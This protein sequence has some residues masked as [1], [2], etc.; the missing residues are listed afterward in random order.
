MPPGNTL[1]GRMALMPPS[2]FDRLAQLLN[3]ITP[4]CA[5]NGAPVPLTIGEPQDAP[6][7]FVTDILNEQARAYGRYPPI[8]GTPT[9][10]AACARWLMRRFAVPPGALDADTQI[11]PLAG[12]REGLFYTLYALVPDE[13]AGGRPVVLVPNPFYGVYPA[14]VL[15]A[16]AEPY[17]VPSRRETGF[18][19]DFA[20][21][22]EDVLRRTVAAFYCSPSNP[23]S[24]CASEADWRRVFATADTYEFTVLA[25]ECYAEIYDRDAPV[26]ALSV[27]YAQSG[28]CEKLISFHSLSKRSNLPGLRSGFMV[29]PAPVMAALRG[30]RNLAAPQIPIPAMAASAAAWDDDAHVEES[31]ALYRRRFDVAERLL[32]NLGGFRRPPGG[33]YLW[34]DV[35][36]GAG[37][38]A[39]LWRRSGVRVMPGAF[40]GREEIPG[41][42]ASNPGFSYVRIALVHDLVTITAALERVAETLD[43][44]DH[45]A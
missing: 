29:G 35:G 6:P 33:F 30:F 32:G 14:A 13:K 22:P 18:L 34:L 10:R 12:S 11:L 41:N 38:A 27:R 2:S 44:W 40:M 39:E 37:F 43:R 42:P 1:P 28:G 3:P 16:G 20:C 19:P 8:A 7:R 23:E 21:V 45:P 31:R 25:D 4:H 9:L 24:A 36:D 5:V 17:Y 15:A 26:G